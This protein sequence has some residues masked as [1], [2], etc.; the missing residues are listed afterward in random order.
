MIA[1]TQWLVPDREARNKMNMKPE[2]PGPLKDKKIREELKAKYRPMLDEGVANMQKALD[3]DKE[4]DEAMAY[5]NL[6]IRYRADL[7]DTPGRVQEGHRQRR[8]LGPEGAGTPR[9]S[10]PKGMPKSAGGITNDMSESSVRRHLYDAIPRACDLWALPPRHF[11]GLEFLL[12]LRSYLDV[13]PA[14]CSTKPTSESSSCSPNSRPRCA[15]TGPRTTW[16]RSRRPSASPP[17]HHKRQTA[18]FR[19]ALHDPSAAWCRT[20]W[21]TCSMDM[22]CLETGLLHDVVEDT[23]ATVEEIR[24]N[25]GEEVARCVDGVT[26]LSKLNFYSREDRQ[27]ESFRKMLL[28]MVNDIRVIIVK[29]AD[30]L[31]NMR[32]LRLPVAASGRSASRKETM[33]I[34][35][36]IAHRLGMGKIRGELEDL[37]FRYLEPDGYADVMREHRDRKR[38][39]E[40]RVPATRSAS[41]VE[42]ELRAR[43]HSGPRRRPHEARLFGLSEDE[44]A[45]DR[46]DQVYDLLALR[47]ITDSVKNCYAA[48]GVIHNEWH[49]MPGRIKDFIA[50]PRP[51]LYQS[52][53]TSVIGPSGQPF[54]V[55]I[56]TEEMHRIAEEGIAAHWKYKEGQEGPG[57]G[58][59]AH[60]LAAPAGRVAAGD[61]AIRASSCPLSKWTCTR[62]KSTPSRRRAR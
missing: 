39:A 55:Q 12:Q 13:S 6:L 5:M 30:R 58:R 38:H 18:R 33:E 31:H 9:R 34:Y 19:R 14:S 43:G 49:P 17:T 60:R 21:P 40:R 36:P 26:K 35:A 46:L 24:K 4:Y 11:A 27:A 7:D 22:V 42:A 20:P 57:A 54:E 32:T 45:E 29:L 48:L 1:W 44:A 28:A 15:S 3:I 41:T 51:N 25:F 23:S 53:H 61:A 8:R 47:I 10:R 62:R 59:P 37:S 52:L 16:R 56:R 50:I 2:D